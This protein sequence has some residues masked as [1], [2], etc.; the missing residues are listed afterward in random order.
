MALNSL[1]CPINKESIKRF[2][3][4]YI[5][6]ILPNSFESHF[7][8]AGGCFKSLLN[9]KRTN[10]LDLWPAS[11]QDR[12]TLLEELQE[13]GAILKLDG[14]FNTTLQHPDLPRIEVTKKCPPSLDYCLSHFDLEL[15]CVAV[16]FKSG[17]VIDSHI[18]LGLEN[19]IANREVRMVTRLQRH[20]YNLLTLK[21]LHKYANE[22][23]FV[24]PTSSIQSLWSI[25]YTSA[26]EEERQQLLD[27]A[28]LNLSDVPIE[29]RIQ[30]TFHEGRPPE[31]CRPFNQTEKESICKAFLPRYKISSDKVAQHKGEKPLALFL[32]GL[33]GAG[34]TT[35]LSHILH[36]LGL[37]QEDDFIDIDMDKIRS[38]HVQFN[39]ELRGKAI[40]ECGNIQKRVIYKDLISWFND[41]ADAE[42][43]FY[44]EFDS[45]VQI[46]LREHHN[47]ILP[48]HR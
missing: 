24:V 39:R 19:G 18:Y 41:G 34:K 40:D 5:N 47:F 22:L 26:T 23:G 9:H 48:V 37:G 21:R 33:A 11:D 32:T 8:L 20:R 16:E 15:S 12:A 30:R 44:K 6:A 2:A 42:I 28:K 31:A 3:S 36:E 10:D 4:E 45:I 46:I 14:E 35:V 7:C 38:H 25:A 13:Q 17:E 29:A 43:T 27:A 1:S